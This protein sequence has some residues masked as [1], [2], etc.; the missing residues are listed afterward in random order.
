M[1][2][3]YFYYKVL[4]FFT[5]FLIC[6]K[7]I[8]IHLFLLLIYACETLN[9]LTKYKHIRKW[10]AF[11]SAFKIPFNRWKAQSQRKQMAMCE[12]HSKLNIILRSKCSNFPSLFL[13]VLTQASFN[14]LF[15]CLTTVQPT[16]WVC[17]VSRNIFH[18]I[19]PLLHS[20]FPA[21][22]FTRDK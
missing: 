9:K 12:K 14:V 13:P 18:F 10:N 8:R 17:S 6:L 4:F 1:L 21:E 7:N 11:I 20:A 19:C 2:L 3:R 15:P 16:Y 5:N 22:Y